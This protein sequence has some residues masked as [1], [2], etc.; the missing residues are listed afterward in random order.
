[1]LLTLGF[2]AQAQERG[3]FPG[4]QKMTSPAERAER[5]AEMMQK[6]VGLTDKQYKKVYK[7]FKKDYQ[8]RQDLMEER[9]GGMPPMGE[10]PE[11]MGGPGGGPGMGGPRGGMGGP[12][13][14][15]GMGGGPRGGGMPPQGEMSGRPRPEGFP[16]MG[17]GGAEVS[18]EYIEKQDRKLRKI[19]TEEQYGQW[20][21]KHP[22][23]H[24]ELPPVEFNK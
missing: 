10:R 17:P 3:A 13:G 6:E 19:L 23:E 8:Y 9:M 11:G 1:M 4:P 12:G 18:D 2:F 20:R 5:K 15:P 16:G 7:L 21:A 14:G 24:R 22:I